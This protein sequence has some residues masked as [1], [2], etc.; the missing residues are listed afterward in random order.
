MRS[1]D[2]CLEDIYRFTHLK[3]CV[4]EVF[5]HSAKPTLIKM[6]RN[7]GKSQGSIGSI[8]SFTVYHLSGAGTGTFSRPCRVMPSHDLQGNLG[9]FDLPLGNTLQAT[10]CLLMFCVGCYFVFF[11]HHQWKGLQFSFYSQ[12]W[13]LVHWLIDSSQKM[14]Q[15]LLFTHHGHIPFF[16]GCA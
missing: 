9:E 6:L 1:T 3:V 5:H 14:F 8:L 7:K 13:D 11:D 2:F 16:H 15:R 4:E 10:G 12:Y